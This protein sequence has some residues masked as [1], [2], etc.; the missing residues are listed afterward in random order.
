MSNL[1]TLIN[2]KINSLSETN[3]EVETAN[4]L[5]K[6]VP[7]VANLCHEDFLDLIT[8]F[9]IVY[10]ETTFSD[11]IDEVN[12]MQNFLKEV[13]KLGYE[14][15]LI[16]SDACYELREKF[17]DQ[18]GE[19]TYNDYFSLK[20][21]DKALKD[22]KKLLKDCKTVLSINEINNFLRWMNDPVLENI[23]CLSLC[24][25][26]I[27]IKL[28]ETKESV[29][30]LEIPEYFS[31]KD[32]RKLSNNYVKDV[33]NGYIKRMNEELR[34]DLEDLR[35]CREKTINDVNV[36]KRKINKQLK[37]LQIIL[38]KLNKNE[39]TIGLL[40]FTDDDQ[41]KYF[42][43]V[44]LIK[45]KNNNYENN[46]QTLKSFG[47]N[48][49]NK[50]EKLFY[51]YG[52]NFNLLTK[53]EQNQLMVL[54]DDTKIEENLR[55]LSTSS[56]KFLKEDD[57]VFLDILLL[58]NEN[59]LQLDSLFVR[60]KISQNFIL[61]YGKK[62]NSLSIKILL[63]NINKLD[64]Q[65]VNFESLSEYNDSLLLDL[66]LKIF[67]VIVEYGINFQSLNLNRYEFLENPKLLTVIDNFIEIGLVN[68]IK[69][70]PNLININSLNVVKR[71]IL[72]KQLNID[73]LNDRNTINQT[74][75]CGKDF[76]IG[77]DSLDDYTY[78]NFYNYMDKEM[79]NILNEKDNVEIIDE[80]PSEIS[81]IENYKKNN[82]VY[83]IGSNYFSRIKVLRCLKSLIDAGYTNYK[84]MLFNALIYKYPNYL[85]LEL[86]ENL[87][88]L[89]TIDVK[90]QLIY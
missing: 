57:F 54:S 73:Y 79:Y 3:V 65:K 84:E 83:M 41:L 71:I 8:C 62:F 76:Y 38:D 27:E 90:K 47:A 37:N 6:F 28:E 89:D 80:I 72:M 46:F 45:V 13:E 55:F 87:N 44:E 74:A 58:D 78:Q 4:Y 67:D 66:N 60:N 50:L 1:I 33:T 52:Y 19:Y 88:N 25:K 34:S 86:I 10:N 42:I 7:N 40:D 15:Y 53:G 14:D 31:S 29:N 32:C 75:R 30:E 82:Q 61:K 12:I 69:N 85:S 77:D 36:K 11:A 68:Q 5:K 49:I 64:L 39:I 59:L 22:F 20:S 43:L 48:P 56:L 9:Y 21:D 81:F 63:K 26:G 70:L 16:F 23:M 17:K 2:N 18:L 35:I 24:L 51:K